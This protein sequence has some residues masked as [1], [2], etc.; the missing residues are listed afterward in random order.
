MATKQRT[1]GVRQ[2]LC[3][4]VL[5]GL[6]AVVAACGNASS[7][8]K[9]A[10]TSTTAASTGTGGAST[11][12]PGVT[13]NQIRFAALGT[14][15]NN[16]TGTCVLECYLYGIKSYFDWR[17]SQGGV[18]GKKLVVTK[19]LDDALANN[20]ARALEI[21]SANDTFGTF[22]AAELAT[23]WGNL[24]K[25]N[26][27]TYVW[28]INPAEA[29]GHDMIFGQREV[30]CVTCTQRIEAYAAKL[31]KA[32]KVA[33]LGYGVSQSSKDCANGAADSIKKYSSDIGGTKVA[34]VNDGLSFGLPNGIAPEVSAMK[35]A[36]VDMIIG[37]LDLNGMKTLA[38][39]LARQGMSNVTLYHTNTYDQKFVKEAGSLFN[40][41]YVLAEFRP[42]EANA[43]DSGLATY[44]QW[45]AKNNYPLS[46]IA[47]VGWINADEAYQGIKAAGSNFTRQSVI[48]AT[49]KMTNYTAGGLVQPIDWS[50][51]HVAPT[52]EDPATNGPKYDCGALVK[53]QDGTFHMVGDPNKPWICWP[54]STRDWSDPKAMNFN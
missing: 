1:F 15:S 50:R 25:A 19:V 27:P 14:N 28:A 47:M 31:A 8:N 22:S 18:D 24:A 33:T 51:Q 9:S 4:A 41:G 32:K 30:V 37:C 16:P 20:Q 46:E 29:T 12:V 49:N 38:Q 5:L 42:F 52:E 2:A 11:G 3:L 6:T 7:N 23:G 34:Y 36:G 53:I 40:G 26:I 44:K 10:S 54:G 39:E 43:G 21:V 45:M 17:N 48:D 35:S 13:A